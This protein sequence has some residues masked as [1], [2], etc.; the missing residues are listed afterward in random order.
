[1][2]GNASYKRAALLSNPRADVGIG[3]YAG[4]EV[5]RMY[6]PLPPVRFR[7]DVGIGPYAGDGGSVGI[8][9]L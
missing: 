7:A 3:P 5:F 6:P 2:G 9:L 4:D 1:M 8:A